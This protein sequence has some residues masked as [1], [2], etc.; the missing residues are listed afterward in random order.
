MVVG[1]FNKT[2]FFFGAG[3]G[4]HSNDARGATITEEPVDRVA[5][6]TAVSSP[7]GASPLLVQTKGAEV[8]VRTKVIPGLDSS[9]SVFILDQ[10]SEL[11]FQR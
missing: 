7:L 4:M 5:N 10:A 9:V 3:Y 8:G 2:E 11:V 6:P 1:P